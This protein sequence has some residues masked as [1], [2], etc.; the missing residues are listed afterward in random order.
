MTLHGAEA[1]GPLL[2]KLDSLLDDISQTAL[3]ETDHRA[4]YH[5]ILHSL[6][7]E[8]PDLTGDVWVRNEH[9]R[10]ICVA[11]F[12][13]PTDSADGQDRDR[14]GREELIDR[15]FSAATTGLQENRIRSNGKTVALSAEN[16]LYQPVVLDQEVVA[17]IRFGVGSHAAPLAQ[18]A[19][20]SV[21]SALAEIAADF[22]RN[23]QLRRL[24]NREGFWLQI[25]E[26]CRSIFHAT[27]IE[28]AAFRIANEGRVLCAGDRVSVLID[29][30][31]RTRILAIS[32][33]SHIENNSEFARELKTLGNS[34][35]PLRERLWVPG[36]EISRLPQAEAVV[37]DFMGRFG[38]HTLC[39]APLELSGS[40]LSSTSVS[41]LIEYFH[42][43]DGG[44]VSIEERVDYVSNHASS[45]LSS[46]IRYDAIPLRSFLEVLA[47]KASAFRSR[48]KRLALV[49]TCLLVCLAA[50][51]LIPAP[52]T[53][54]AVG[55]LQPRNRKL[56]F[57]PREGQV[58]RIHT[59]DGA[60]VGSGE[61]LIEIR[62]DD[63]EFQLTQVR[64]KI[65][66]TREALATAQMEKISTRSRDRADPGRAQAS[67]NEAEL[68][69][70]LDGLQQE[71]DVLT[72]QQAELVIR[73]PLRGEIVTWEMGKLLSDRPVQPGNVLMEIAQLDGPWD[74]LVY[75]PDDL[76]GHVVRAMDIEGARLPVEFF[77]ETDPSRPISGHLSSLS[78]TIDHDEEYGH[79]ASGTVEI[80][81]PISFRKPGASA[82][83]KIY[84]GRRSLGYVWF[85]DVIDF[86]QRR[87]FF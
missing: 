84:A 55:E 2:P 78:L 48:R 38:A 81:E 59:T 18:D 69:A 65:S 8:F 1:E 39:F 20:A 64:G 10:V 44:A 53:V 25:Q 15:I 62:N 82:V 75:I 56:I 70:L 4:F 86:L 14:N 5:H 22:H 41:L 51:I 87:L 79:S 43:P 21:L 19:I 28:E 31:P 32:G 52:F 34:L 45:A 61:P 67:G 83:A 68:R 74:L 49:G 54:R 7:T 77:L 11:E 24:Q 73:S 13:N 47:G 9:G 76:V 85:H 71:L 40:I 36:N 6:R 37:T 23:R 60:Q 16:D 26:Y 42:V 58:V 27:G 30:G 46:A 33:V 66:A 72:R 3:T 29:E 17:V 80:S 63:V 50:L 57:A 35:A 12:A